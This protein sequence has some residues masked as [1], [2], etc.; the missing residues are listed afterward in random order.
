[1]PSGATYKINI[2][3]RQNTSTNLDLEMHS[4]GINPNPG[5]GSPNFSFGR[6][7]HIETSASSRM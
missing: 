1:M 2:D 6:V 7:D 5:S 3:P 4:P